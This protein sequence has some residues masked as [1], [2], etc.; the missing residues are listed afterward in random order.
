MLKGIVR[1]QPESFP[2]LQELDIVFYNCFLESC[3]YSSVVER[4]LPKVNVVG[5]SPIARFLP[6]NSH[7]ICRW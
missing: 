2:F 6:V 3:G 5:S 1:D 7:I 4:H